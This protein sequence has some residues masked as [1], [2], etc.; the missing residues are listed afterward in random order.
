M[1]LKIN[2][3]KADIKNGEPGEPR[4]C[5]IAIAFN[6]VSMYNVKV[7]NRVFLVDDSVYQLPKMAK[8]FTTLFDNGYPVK[9][10]SFNVRIRKP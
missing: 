8:N 3:T 6:R 1:K 2:V 10:F 7:T 4:Y 9:P 5:P